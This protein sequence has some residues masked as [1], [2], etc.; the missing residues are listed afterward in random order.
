V[1]S[2]LS[3]PHGINNKIKCET[4]NKKIAFLTNIELYFE[5]DKHMAI[6]TMEDK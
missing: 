6:V 5:N 1:G 3:L 2:Q 4:K